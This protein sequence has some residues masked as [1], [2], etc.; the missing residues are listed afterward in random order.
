M[1]VAE[2]YVLLVQAPY[3]I[4]TEYSHIFGGYFEP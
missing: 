3:N 2:R 1:D 4:I